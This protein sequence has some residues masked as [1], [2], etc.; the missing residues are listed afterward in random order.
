MP[1]PVCIENNILVE[2]PKAFQDELV[3][4]NGVKFYQDTTF[5]PEWNVTLQGK[6]ASVP[7]RVTMGDGQIHSLDPDRPRIRQIIKP[8]DDIVFNYLVVMKRAQTDNK[9]DVFSRDDITSPYTTTWSNYNGLKLVRVYLMND[10]WEVGLFDTSTRTWVDRIKGGEADVESFM[11]KYM[12]TENI[13]FN[14]SNLLPFDDKDYWMVDYA[15]AVAIKRAA[16]VFD[17]IGDYVLVE[18]IREPNRGTYQ[19][20]IEVYNIE[21]D[22][23]YR[24]IGRVISIGEPLAGDTKLS[25]KPNDIICSDIR[26]VE[27]YE[28]DGH[29]YWVIRQK[30]IYGKQS[31]TNDATRN[32]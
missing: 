13:G 22:T 20:L 28:I 25:I 6:V 7:T 17:M 27:K 2:L 19:G 10:K 24:A 8:G 9:A 30:Y 16:G 4:S 11:G 23:D 3:S 5:R 18:P 31:E 29:D 12:P 1:I 15:N 21:Q 32:S 14:Y 26:Y